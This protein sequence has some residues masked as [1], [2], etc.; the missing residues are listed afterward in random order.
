MHTSGYEGSHPVLGE[1][2]VLLLSSRVKISDN[3]PSKAGQV[4][5]LVCTNI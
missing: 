5:V 2:K 3:V 1:A 4:N